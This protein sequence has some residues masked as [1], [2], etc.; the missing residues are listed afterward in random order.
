[1]ITDN[2]EQGHT[3]ITLVILF[4]FHYTYIRGVQLTF[5]KCMH[6]GLGIP[7]GM[8]VSS[9]IQIGIWNITH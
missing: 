4:N 2:T 3:W 8:T 9:N 5:L 7:M 6:N 1:M